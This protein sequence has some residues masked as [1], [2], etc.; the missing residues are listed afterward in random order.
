MKKAIQIGIAAVI[1]VG[2]V[3][4][5]AIAF[6]G[7]GKCFGNE[8]AKAALEAGDFAAWKEA[9]GKELTQEKFEKHQQ[10][11]MQMGEK[12]EAMEAVHAALEAEDYEAWKTAIADI[13]EKMSLSEKIT[14][15][16]FGT[17]V[18]LYKAK[19]DGDFEKVQELKE[20]LGIEGPM[21]FGNGKC[22]GKGRMGKCSGMGFGEEHVC[23]GSC[24]E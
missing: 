19:Q 3:A 22:P 14:E 17:L 18:E 10:R 7:F 6:G 9:V 1:L 5:G 8:E 12:R 2:L 16:N 20:E 15:E 24:L 4:V 21:G 23:D 11:Y 13:E